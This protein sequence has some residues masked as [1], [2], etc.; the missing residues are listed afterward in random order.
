MSRGICGSSNIEEVEIGIQML[1]FSLVRVQVRT[2]GYVIICMKSR[3]TFSRERN[4]STTVELSKVTMTDDLIPH[5][6]R[7][8]GRDQL[9]VNRMAS[10]Y[11]GIDC[12][13]I[14]GT[15]DAAQEKIATV[16]DSSIGFS[17]K[18]VNY[19][20]STINGCSGSQRLTRIEELK[21]LSTSILKK[22][23]GQEL[24]LL[25]TETYFKVLN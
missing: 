14:D 24:D 2:Y 11:K 3:M 15:M 25:I 23:K 4:I 6:L 20:G 17:A 8:F 12:D 22:R 5:E 9:K 13:R 10:S 7:F 18:S 16:P 1:T 19:A 21:K